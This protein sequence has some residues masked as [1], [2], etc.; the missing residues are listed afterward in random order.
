MSKM[1]GLKTITRLIDRQLLE[2]NRRIEYYKWDES[3]HHEMVYINVIKEELERE[4]YNELPDKEKKKFKTTSATI[5]IPMVSADVLVEQN[6]SG[7]GI[8]REYTL[9][10]IN[11]CIQAQENQ[12]SLDALESPIT[13][14]KNDETLA[15]AVYMILHEFGHWHDL[16]VKNMCVFEYLTDADIKKELFEERMIIQSKASIH[17]MTKGSISTEIRN[18]FENWME[19]YNATPTESLANEYADEHFVKV[20][21]IVL[22][23]YSEG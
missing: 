23:H 13:I 15:I 12:A 11:D 6:D 4:R 22:S 21:P 1:R 20:Y 5:Y 10:R 9:G 16:Y 14:A 17:N 8:S 19:K 2:E 3:F 18:N 7:T